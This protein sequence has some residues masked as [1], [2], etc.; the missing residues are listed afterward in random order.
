MNY[1]AWRHHRYL[2]L[3][4]LSAHPLSDLML[5]IE[6]Q[7]DG[8]L[9]TKFDFSKCW[10]FRGSTHYLSLGCRNAQGSTL[11]PVYAHMLTKPV[12]ALHEGLVPLALDH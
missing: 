11:D 4:T 5:R 3:F 9:D 12:K 6:Q 1:P 7:E 2:P 10:H 8:P